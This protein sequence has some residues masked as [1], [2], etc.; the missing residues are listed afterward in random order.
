MR[1]QGVLHVD[2]VGIGL[3]ATGL[4]ALL[5]VLEE[6]ETDGW[7]ASSFIIALS[8]VAL[9]TLTAFIVWELRTPAPAVNLRILRN[10][11][12]SS[13]TF[14]GG[15]LGV[16][17]YGSLILLPVFL[18]R[19]LGYDATQAGLALM[20]RGLSMVILMPIAG[21][22]YNR[23]GVYVMVPFG[24]ILSAYAGFMMARFTQ[25]SSLAQI[26]LPQAVQGAGFAFMF[27]SLATSAL[28]TIPR[29]QMQSATGLFSLTFQLGGS[30]GT[31]II[32]TLLDHRVTIASTNLVRYASL[33][34]PTFVQ[35]WQTFQA[36][37]LARGTDPGTARLQALAVL[38]GLIGQQAAV[39]AFDYAFAVI[40]A[41]FLVCLPLVLLIRRGQAPPE[42]PVSVD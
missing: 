5:T 32:I 25:D 22:L 17:L 29:A 10:L 15:V 6:G 8:V 41:I 16:A 24:L 13:G 20:P 39:V 26:M 37:L 28:S 21:A 4:V 33:H 7:F 40:G 12:F 42:E 2:G 14:I 36:G 34:N 18:Q 31:A 19:L 1:R 23:L 35:W 11:S 30:L 27:V 3:M 9:V 38:K